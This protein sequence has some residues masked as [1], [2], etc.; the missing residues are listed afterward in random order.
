M[1]AAVLSRRSMCE[2]GLVLLNG[3]FYR[4][5]IKDDENTGYASTFNSAGG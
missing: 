5:V 1:Y 3:E 2:T 4:Q